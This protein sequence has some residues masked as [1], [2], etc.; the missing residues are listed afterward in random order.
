MKVSDNVVYQGN[1]IEMKLE[2]NGRESNGKRTRNININYYVVTDFIQANEMKVVYCPTETMIADF[3]IKPM[4]GRLFRLFWNLILN[5]SEED[6]S[7][8]ENLEEL[9]KMENK[10]GSIDRVKLVESDQECVV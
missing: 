10:T 9:T 8:M 4:Q 2:N 7:N 6:I 5:L 3:Y 1:H